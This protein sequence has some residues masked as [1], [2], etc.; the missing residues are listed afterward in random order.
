MGEIAEMMIDGTLCE[1]CGA[2][3]GESQDLRSRCVNCTDLTE[4]PTNLPKQKTAKRKP[5]PKVA[6]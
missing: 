1:C 6:P 5:A 3:L 2:Y 4:D